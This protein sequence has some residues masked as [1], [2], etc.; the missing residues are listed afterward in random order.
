MKF[1]IILGVLSFVLLLVYLRLRPF[2]RM[3]RQMFGV[4]RQVRSVTRDGFSGGSGATGAVNDR[5]MR[6]ESCG[7]WIPAARA[8]KLRSSNSSYCSHEC[9]E[10]A[11]AGGQQRKAA[12]G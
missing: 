1:L 5:L 7:T 6:C 11:A 3:L 4:A 8:V 12:G 2:I 10:S 9:L